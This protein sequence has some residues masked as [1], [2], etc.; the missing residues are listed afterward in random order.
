MFS[1]FILV[2]AFMG[3][4]FLF[5]VWQ[6]SVV[7][8][9]HILSVHSSVATCIASTFWLLW[10]TLQRTGDYCEYGKS[11]WDRFQLFWGLSA[12]FSIFKFFVI[13]AAPL[14]FLSTLAGIP[15]LPHP[16]QHFFDDFV[17]S[18]ILM[19][20]RWHHCFSSENLL[21]RSF[22]TYVKRRNN[23]IM[24]TFPPTPTS[25]ITNSWI[26]FSFLYNWTKSKIWYVV[27][28]NVSVYI[29]KITFFENNVTSL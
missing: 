15:V 10:I 5:A 28:V 11:L 2:V 13:A 25:V 7:C 29:S 16:R 8:S 6:Y 1:K 26:N 14:Y 24:G 12:H 21:K 17:N 3:I 20:L 9:K 18:S 23:T 4:S 22:Q 19:D 27:F